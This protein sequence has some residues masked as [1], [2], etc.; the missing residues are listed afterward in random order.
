MKKIILTYILIVNSVW[1]GVAVLNG[2][3]HEFIVTPGNTYKGTIELKNASDIAQVAM[4]YKA[5]MTTQHTGETFYSDSIKNDRSNLDWIQLSN[6]NLTL[7]SEVSGSV[8]FEI[9]VPNSPDL[10]GT[11]WSVIMIEPRDPIHVQ[12]DESGYSIQS[13]IRYAI[14]IVCNIG[15]TGTT[16]LQFLNISQ[17]HYQ[18]KNYLEVDVKNTGETL[19]KPELSLE[20]FDSEGSGLPIIKAEKQRIFPN[21]SKRYIV[22]IEGIKSGEYQGILIADCNTDDLFG[23]NVT[24][25]LKD[26]Q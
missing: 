13:K 5:N 23:V 21:S 15:E 8:E 3:A 4:I 26:D 16:N 18:G 6:V 24:L 9:N 7:D 14:Q 22:E 25:H 20:L 17:E 19:I 11:Y 10:I 1:A 12:E 2:L